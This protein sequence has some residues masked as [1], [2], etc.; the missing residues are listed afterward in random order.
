M[1][2]TSDAAPLDAVEEQAVHLPRRPRR[3]RR[4]KS[5][6]AWV[7]PSGGGAAP[8]SWRRY[9]PR[10]NLLWLHYVLDELERQAVAGSTPST[11][12]TQPSTRTATSSQRGRARGR[13][14]GRGR[15]SR[16]KVTA[17]RPAA[18]TDCLR[19]TDSQTVS[20]VA[21]VAHRAEQLR[22]TLAQVAQALHPAALARAGTIASAAELVAWAIT[23]GWLAIEDVV[24]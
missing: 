1:V 12:T 15:G 7:G 22:S 4:R 19:L 17:D 24:G 18:A 20:D 10:T 11:D 8:T 13:G 2:I 6:L 14:R 9:C 16:G 5:Q 23:E 3:P 21:A